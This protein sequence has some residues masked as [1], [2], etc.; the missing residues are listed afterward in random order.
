MQR[1][2]TLQHVPSSTYRAQV[3]N[4]AI[5]AI[6]NETERFRT[7]PENE[8]ANEDPVIRKKSNP[9]WA[10]SHGQLTIS[11]RKRR[12]RTTM[13][14]AE[15]SILAQGDP[16]SERPSFPLFLLLILFFLSAGEN[17]CC[18]FVSSGHPVPSLW[19]P[20]PF[21]NHPMDCCQTPS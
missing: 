21:D 7:I 20:R 3:V 10:R 8:Y 1:S 14:V 12:K 4:N 17:C 9:A 19:C 5:L 2:G 15:I 6:S 18:T 16:G 11:N 13:A